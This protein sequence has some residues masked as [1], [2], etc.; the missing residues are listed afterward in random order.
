MNDLIT[1]IKRAPYQSAASFLI[2]FFTL[3]LSLFFFNLTSFLNGILGY[4]ETR[5]HVT[6]YFQ[7]QTQEGDIFK[8]RDSIKAGGK[9]ESVKYISKAEALKIYKEL[10]RDDPLLLEMVSADILPPSLEIYTT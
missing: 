1:S 4:V 10:N 2:L 7:K 9:A 6:V 5:P 3:F 8:I